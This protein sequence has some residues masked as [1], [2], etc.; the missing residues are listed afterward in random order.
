VAEGTAPPRRPLRRDLARLAAAVAVLALVLRGAILEPFL[1]S[2]GGMAPSLLPGDVLVVSKLAYAVRLPF[3]AVTLLDIHPPRRGDVVVFRDPTDPSRRVAKRVVGLPGEVVELREQ[4]VL[5][6]GVPQ[7]R[8]E[9]GAAAYLEPGDGTTPPGEDTCRR[10]R[11]IL[12]LGTPQAGGPLAGASRLAPPE[13]AT[14]L[15]AAPDQAAWAAAAARLAEGSAT[16]HDVLQCRRVRAGRREGPFGPVRPGHLLV[17]GDNR[18]RSA[19]GRAGWEVPVAEVVGRGTLIG[20]SWGPGG[21]GAASGPG[22]RI[23]RLFKPVE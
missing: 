4:V 6:D 2:T 18:D 23:D 1:V 16:A 22:V 12:D 15:P 13:G 5:I 17:L 9:L 11:E 7:A 10:W 21:G 19:D 14:P 20:W 3:T 8:L